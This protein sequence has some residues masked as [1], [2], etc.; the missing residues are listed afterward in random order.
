MLLEIARSLTTDIEAEAFS[1]DGGKNGKT[2]LTTDFT[3]VR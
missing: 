1:T 3:K 2:D